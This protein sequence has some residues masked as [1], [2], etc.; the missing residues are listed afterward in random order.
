MS[1]CTPNLI[2]DQTKL[3]S[4]RFTN[5]YLKLFGC[6]LNDVESTIHHEGLLHRRSIFMEIIFPISHLP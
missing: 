4:K 5:L 2:V 1:M 6:M 3:Q